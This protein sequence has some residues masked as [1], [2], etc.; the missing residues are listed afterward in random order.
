MTHDRYPH[1][2]SHMHINTTYIYMYVVGRSDSVCCHACRRRPSTHIPSMWSHH[3]WAAFHGR[4]PLNISVQEFNF[5]MMEQHV[6]RIL[7][8]IMNMFTEKPS[9]CD[10]LFPLPRLLDASRRRMLCMRHGDNILCNVVTTGIY[11]ASNKDVCIRKLP[12]CTRLRRTYR[13]QHTYENFR[14]MCFGY[15]WRCFA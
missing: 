3:S 9:T 10:P 15:S 14:T 8:L 7:C 13:F 11:Y 1:S 12:I 4:H 5:V 6:L 2:T